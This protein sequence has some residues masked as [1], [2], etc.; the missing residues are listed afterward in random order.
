M[1]DNNLLKKSILLVDDEEQLL[2]L[3][4]EVLI[5]EGFSNIYE[6]TNG[7][8]GILIAKDVN[9]DIIL[10]DV[11]LPDVEGFTVCEK[12]R[13]FSFCPIIFLT[14]KNEDNNKL[15]GLEVGGDDYVT[16]PFNIKEV[17]LRIKAQLRRNSYIPK[18]NK[19][20]EIKF[21]HIAINEEEGTVKK[22]GQSITLTAKEFALVLMLAKNK[23]K[24][25]SKNT[26]CEAIWG[27]EYYGY[28]NTIMVHIRHLREKLED[29]PSNPRYIKTLKGLGYKLVSE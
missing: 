18:E 25:L 29:E 14:A 7:V 27:Y 1:Y 10:L 6:A 22:H 8:D 15:Q 11:N 21:G 20:L 3:L 12:I 24:I 13:G 5:K 2:L 26:I 28:D 17:V 19:K 9:P 4:R 23:N 16:K